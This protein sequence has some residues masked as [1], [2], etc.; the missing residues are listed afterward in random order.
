MTIHMNEGIDPAVIAGEV[1]VYWNIPKKHWSI[2]VGKKV[3]AWADQCALV[4]DC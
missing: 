1:A 4:G 2:R 3:V